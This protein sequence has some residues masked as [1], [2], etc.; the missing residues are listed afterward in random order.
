M[1]PYRNLNG[2]SNVVGYE[3]NENSLHVI[4]KSGPCR[5]YLYNVDRPGRAIVEQ[6]NTLALQGRGL[7]SYIFSV[8]KSNYARKW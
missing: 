1:T 5:N 6:M 3:A 4:F 2:D 7:N 8:V